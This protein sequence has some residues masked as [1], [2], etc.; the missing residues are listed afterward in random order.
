MLQ[1]RRPTFGV[2]Q[3]DEHDRAA[4][5][6]WTHLQFAGNQASYSLD[7][8]LVSCI[9]NIELKEWCRVGLVG[10]GVCA[11]DGWVWPIIAFDMTVT[12]KGFRRIFLRAR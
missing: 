1:T 6:R 8:L 9:R 11:S 7:D 5:C 12:T 10:D 2:L 3:N 4:E